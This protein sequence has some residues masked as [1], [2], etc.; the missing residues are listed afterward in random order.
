[1]IEKKSIYCKRNKYVKK[2]Y[3]GRNNKGHITIRSKQGLFIK[4]TQLK[5]INYNYIFLKEIKQFITSDK[6][7]KLQI[8]NKVLNTKL[9]RYVYKVV[10]LNSILYN[11]YKYLPITKNT[12][13]GDIISI[14]KTV[15]LKI[16]NIMPLKQ[17][18][19]GSWIH[20]IEHTPTKGAVFVK[21]AKISA[22]LIYI[23]AKYATVKLPSGEIRLIS[24]DV[25]CILG[26][27]NTSPFFFQKNKA[28]TTRFLGKR[29]KVRGVAMNAY[30]HPH[31]GGEGKNSIGRSS[32]YSPWGIAS[33][34]IITRK[35]KKYSSRLILKK[36]N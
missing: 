36:S 14:G 8:I 17:V 28:G 18:P 10:C 25:F 26:E 21:N 23:G 24:K 30:D 32:A 5:N 1:M 19:C 34:G 33:R 6:L 16:G 27:L 31:G 7:I 35:N 12:L 11:Q 15:P 22:F 13:E 9:Q 4:T 3:F 2:Y 29:P 20:N